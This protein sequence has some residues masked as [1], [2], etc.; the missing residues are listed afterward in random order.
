LS[1]ILLKLFIETFSIFPSIANI[2]ASCIIVVWS[3]IMQRKFTFK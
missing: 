2:L 3:Y 1:W